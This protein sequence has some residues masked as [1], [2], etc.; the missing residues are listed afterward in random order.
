MTTKVKRMNLN[1][2]KNQLPQPLNLKQKS[3]AMMTKVQM[4]LQPLD[5]QAQKH[6]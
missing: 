2:P 3:L 4:K 6:K 5:Q 1:H